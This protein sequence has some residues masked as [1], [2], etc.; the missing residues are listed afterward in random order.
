LRVR[1]T[2]RLFHSAAERA[3]DSS[4]LTSAASASP[5]R[6]AS[7][8]L[9]ASPAAYRASSSYVDA[10]G[11]Q[12]AVEAV[13]AAKRPLLMLG[14]RCRRPL[15]DETLLTGLNYWRTNVGVALRW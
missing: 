9:P 15:E 7:V 1:I 12:N 2:P 8:R 14:S 6:P 3:F 11:V 13:A 4:A 10:A 5:S